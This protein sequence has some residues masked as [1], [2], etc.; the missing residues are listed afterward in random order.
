M[1]LLGHSASVFVFT[2]PTPFFRDHGVQVCNRL[3]QFAE[4]NRLLL[5]E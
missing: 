2:V 5:L 4:C 1:F 3:L